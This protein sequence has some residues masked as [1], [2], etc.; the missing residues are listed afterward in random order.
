MAVEIIEMTHTLRTDS[1][2]QKWHWFF[3]SF[4]QW[5]ALVFTLYCLCLHPLGRKANRGWRA[6]EEMAVLRWH[7]MSSGIHTEAHQWNRILR[8]IDHAKLQRRRALQAMK[9]KHG[10]ARYQTSSSSS[11]RDNTSGPQTRITQQPQMLQPQPQQI[12]VSN[13]RPQQEEI[14][15]PFG[16]D[17][18][19]QRSTEHS[20]AQNSQRQAFNYDDFF[21]TSAMLDFDF[22]NFHQF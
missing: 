12:L 11:L 21:D 16:D 10:V 9:L 6:V 7:S 14:L 17:P 1:R 3:G 5:Y 4:H 15:P 22:D 18:N 13:T 2:L 20:V 19:P 8:M